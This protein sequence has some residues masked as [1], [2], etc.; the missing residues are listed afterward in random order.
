M[1]S[2]ID[3]ENKIGGKIQKGGAQSAGGVVGGGGG[4]WFWGG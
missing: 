3:Y 4:V 2:R 1:R